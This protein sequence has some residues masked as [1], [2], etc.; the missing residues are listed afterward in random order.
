MDLI[1]ED[2]S[3][4]NFV[5][6]G[7]QQNAEGKAFRVVQLKDG[8]QAYAEVTDSRR[9]V[10]SEGSFSQGTKHMIVIE[11]DGTRKEAGGNYQV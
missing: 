9:Y 5:Y 1:K 11:P 10:L 8:T 4:I 2:D 3:R 6:Q 7:V